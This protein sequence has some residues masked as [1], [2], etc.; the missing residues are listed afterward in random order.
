MQIDIKLSNLTH[1]P[2]IQPLVEE[3][4][5]A[6]EKLLAEPKVSRAYVEIGKS[7]HHQS[8]DIFTVVINLITPT[9]NFRAAAESSTLLST[10]DDAR[11][12]LSRELRSKKG[13]ER[14]FSRRGAARVKNFIRGLGP[15]R[16][17]N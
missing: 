3:K 7:A 14:R 12:E 6:V 16:W 5:A 2:D 9:A 1:S 10:L 15:K 13:K 17:R 8:G 11:D 4:L